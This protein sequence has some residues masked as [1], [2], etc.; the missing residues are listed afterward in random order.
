MKVERM[1]KKTRDDHLLYSVGGMILLCVM[2]V[3]VASHI[4][5]SRQVPQEDT[6]LVGTADVTA[7]DPYIYV[8][9]EPQESETESELY[10]ILREY[11][12]KIGVFLENG[13]LVEVLEIQIKTLPQADQD[14]LREGIT[15]YYREDL[16]SILEDY[17]E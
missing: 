6:S 17:S 11:Q 10:C 13:D 5:L 14:L 15:V 12:G 4:L 7:S 8:Y 3:I 2:F 16:E 9:L 1:K